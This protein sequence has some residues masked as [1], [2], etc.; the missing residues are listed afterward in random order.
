MSLNLYVGK[1]PLKGKNLDKNVKTWE[2]TANPM[3]RF[4]TSNVLGLDLSTQVWFGK[5]LSTL[6]F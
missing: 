3:L 2:G 1:L 4:M 6:G 5:L